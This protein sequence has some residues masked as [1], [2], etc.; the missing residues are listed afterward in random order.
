MKTVINTFEFS[1][2]LRH[3]DWTRH[4]PLSQI[5]LDWKNP[6]YTRQETKLEAGEFCIKKNNNN[7]IKYFQCT[8]DKCP[9]WLMIN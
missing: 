6:N 2:A 4:I 3:L 8:A 1:A 9:D 5:R 7:K